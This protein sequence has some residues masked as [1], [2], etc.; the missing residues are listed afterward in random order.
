MTADLPLPVQLDLLR[1]IVQR[2]ERLSAD[3]RWSH[4]ASGSR[5]SMIKLIDVLEQS[6][7]VSQAERAHAELL[8]EEGCKLLARA[9]RELGDPALAMLR[10]SID[11]M[12]PQDYPA[13]QEIYQSGM[14]TGCATFETVA[15]PWQAWDAGHLQVCRLVARNHNQVIGWAAL[16]SFSKRAAY[17]GVAEV[18]IYVAPSVQGH[19]VGKALLRSLLAAA[20]S[21]GVWTV[22]ASLFAENAASLRLHLACGFREV[23]RRERI[24]Q[25]DDVWHDTLLLERR[26]SKMG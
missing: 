20:E 25:R 9:A 13:V 6:A 24:A 19:G 10:F 5:G 7:Q 23:G 2:L 22:Q 26:S 21:A 14:D 8:I 12:L 1:M 4:L 16:S 15:P 3:S 17:S 11:A 18:S